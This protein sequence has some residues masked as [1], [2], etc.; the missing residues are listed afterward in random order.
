MGWYCKHTNLGGN[1]ISGD[2]TV[3]GNAEFVVIYQSQELSHMMMLL[4]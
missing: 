3:S 2:L 4:L 1:N